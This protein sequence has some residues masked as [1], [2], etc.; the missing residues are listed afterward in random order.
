MVGFAEGA[1]AF[2]GAEAKAAELASPSRRRF[3]PN[4]LFQL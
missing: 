1:E 2:G 3:L 4:S